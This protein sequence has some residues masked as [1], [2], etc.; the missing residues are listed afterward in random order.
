MIDFPRGPADQAKWDAF[1]TCYA[2]GS[3]HAL[4]IHPAHYHQ[5]LFVDLTRHLSLFVREL[6]QTQ[7]RN[8]GDINASIC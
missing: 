2:F 4:L 8:D 3:E 6:Q 5:R 1:K 7:S